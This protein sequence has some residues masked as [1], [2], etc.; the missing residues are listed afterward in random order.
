MNSYRELDV[1]QRGIELVV[2]CYDIAKLLPREER[3]EL[4]AQ[5]RSAAVSVPTNVA[6]GH[7]RRGPNE[8]AHHV[9][10]AQGSA[11]EVDTLLVIVDRLGFVTRA[12][13]RRASEERQRASRMLARLHTSLVSAPRS[14]VLGPRSPRPR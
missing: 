4:S 6:E 12:R 11:A 14:P 13:L 3:F 5:L 9:S 1:W 2:A 7:D 8:Y 10:M